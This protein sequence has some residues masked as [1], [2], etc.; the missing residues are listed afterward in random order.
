[1]TNPT[2]HSRLLAVLAAGGLAIGALGAAAVPASADTGHTV[3][4]TEHQHGS[5]TEYGDTD[6]CTGDTIAPTITGN[7]VMHETFFPAGDEVWGTFTTEGTGSFLQPSSG[8]LFSGRVTVWGNFNVNEQ[9]WNQTFT[10]SFRLS[11]V[12]PDGVTHYETGHAVAHVAF[13]AVDPANPV[14]SFDSMNATCS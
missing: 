1:M 2:A 8:L 3:T 7:S 14:V 9:N 12:G 4:M 10:A 13:N 6:F 11:A 5:W